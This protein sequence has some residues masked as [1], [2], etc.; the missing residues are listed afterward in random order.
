[1]R[2]LLT[3][4]QQECQELILVI[5]SLSNSLNDNYIWNYNKLFWLRNS[6]VEA[7]RLRNIGK[8]IGFTNIRFEDKI[9]RQ[10]EVM[11]QKDKDRNLRRDAGDS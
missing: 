6:S 11:D 5:H 4:N 7:V 2:A 10:I 8:E 1:M 9:I 3:V